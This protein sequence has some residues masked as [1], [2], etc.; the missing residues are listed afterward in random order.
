MEIDRMHPSIMIAF[1][2]ALAS[3]AYGW[4]RD[5]STPSLPGVG[6]DASFQKSDQ[7]HWFTKCPHCGDI[8]EMLHEFPRNVIELPKNHNLH[9]THYWLEEDDTHAYICTKC[10][11]LVSDETRI[12]GAYHPLIPGNKHIRGYQVSQLYCA[13]ISATQLMRKRED[14]K[15]DQLFMNYV[16][17]S[18]YLGDNIMITE[19]DIWRCVDRSITNPYD[20]KRS[21]VCI[22]GD[23]GNDS[24]GIAG[25]NL[26]AQ[27]MM[28]LDI[29]HIDDKQIIVTGKQIGRAHV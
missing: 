20:F 13:W 5:V 3:S 12:K 29:W 2:E 27:R 25:M 21:E 15:L 28:I 14:Y 9:L 24:W 16:L 26:D 10:K 8:F 7:R 23:W 17:G 18:T 19:A 4:R 1:S 22:G 11:N 6:V